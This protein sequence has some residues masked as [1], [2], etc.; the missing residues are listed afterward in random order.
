MAVALLKASCV[1]LHR[2]LQLSWALSFVAAL[3]TVTAVSL[4]AIAT[5]KNYL[6][7]PKTNGSTVDKRSPQ[8]NRAQVSQTLQHKFDW[9][10]Y[11]DCTQPLRSVGISLT[12]LQRW[13]KIAPVRT[14]TLGQ[15]GNSKQRQ[16]GKILQ[17]DADDEAKR[18]RLEYSIITYNSMNLEFISTKAEERLWIYTHKS[19]ETRSRLYLVF[20]S[21]CP[22]RTFLKFLYFH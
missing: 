19:I 2:L 17:H 10:P 7:L 14:V 6:T 12:P 11:W 16:Q 15:T 18:L 22:F 1:S 9:K 8:A 21:F 13:F 3:G 20:V 4:R 5:P